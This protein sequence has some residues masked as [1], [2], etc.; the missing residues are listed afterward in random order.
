MTSSQI[1]T[2]IEQDVNERSFIQTLET[3]AVTL[4]EL[5]NHRD[6]DWLDDRSLFEQRLRQQKDKLNTF[7]FGPSREFPQMA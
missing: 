6:S 1:F 4:R 3:C 7:G 5:L 2:I